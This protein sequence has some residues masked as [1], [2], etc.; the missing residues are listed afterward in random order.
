MLEKATAT[1]D[2]RGMNVLQ[3]EP[4]RLLKILHP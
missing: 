1:L 2:K 4:P 3:A